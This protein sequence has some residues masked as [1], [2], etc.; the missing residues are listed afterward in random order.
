MNSD[1][2]TLSGTQD[3]V[4]RDYFRRVGNVTLIAY[5]ILAAVFLTMLL[6][7]GNSLTQ[8]LRESTDSRISTGAFPTFR[9]CSMRK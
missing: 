3:G 7:T 1:A 9:A 2:E 6:A 8:S 5:L 4:Q